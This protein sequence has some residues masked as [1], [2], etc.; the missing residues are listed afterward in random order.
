MIKSFS[1]PVFRCIPASFLI[2]IAT[3]VAAQTACDADETDLRFSL[4]V[5]L[6]GTTE[7]AT[8]QAFAKAGNTA[9]QGRYGITVHPDA[10]LFGNDDALIAALKTGEAGFAAP[11][12]EVLHG[13]APNLA[14]IDLLFLFDS[15][16]HVTN[17]LESAWAARLLADIAKDGLTAYGT[18]ATGTRQLVGPAAIHAPQD[19]KDFALARVN[20]GPPSAALIS[21]FGARIVSLTPD[22]RAA[23]RS[24]VLPIID[25]AK[26][27]LGADLIDAVSATAT[28][29]D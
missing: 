9:L 25:R 22:E 3:P 7:G 19:S 18:V 6:G 23:F 14:L 26:V 15:P 17:Y 12:A 11:T 10:S 5:P 27:T 20:A 21:A 1:A 8:A 29:Q 16:L 13:T 28:A 4:A 24:L 2:A